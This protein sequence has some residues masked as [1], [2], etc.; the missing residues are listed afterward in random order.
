MKSVCIQS[1]RKKCQVKC[2]DGTKVDLQSLM[3]HLHNVLR[4]HKREAVKA[5]A[6][7]HAKK[8]LQ[9]SVHITSQATPYCRGCGKAC[10]EA[11]EEVEILICCDLSGGLGNVR[12][13]D[14]TYYRKKNVVDV[15]IVPNIV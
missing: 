15:F 1:A 5:A 13:S 14:S 3:D 12:T 4:N 2:L 11:T 6:T 10:M 8:S 9:E 7:Q